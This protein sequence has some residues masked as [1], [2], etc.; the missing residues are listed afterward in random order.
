MTT[1][2]TL[3]IRV[4][5]KIK[6]IIL[7]RHVLGATNYQADLEE[8][9]KNMRRNVTITYRCHRNFVDVKP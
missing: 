9:K 5:S 3:R 6:I 1:N 8:I 4:E 7:S 2:L